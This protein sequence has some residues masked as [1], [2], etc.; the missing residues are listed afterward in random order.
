MIARK[1]IFLDSAQATTKDLSIG[2]ASFEYPQPVEAFPGSVKIALTSF[3]YTNFFIN[4]SAPNNVIYYSDD[5]LTPQKY[6]ITIPG[7]SYG[8]SDLNDFIQQQQMAQAGVAAVI[9]TI[10]PNYS[11]G[12]ISV[13]FGNVVGWFV[14]FEATS[15]SI[16]GFGV[17]H[18]P[19]TDANTA[20]YSEAAPNAASFNSVDQVK[21]STDLST[22]SIDN[23]ALSSNIIYTST[24]VV[25]IGSVQKDEPQHLLTLESYKLTQKCSSIMVQILDQNNIPINLSEDFSLS[26]IVL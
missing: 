12:K 16:L 2:R 9:W 23:S 5:A 24:P 15:P 18:V 6:T 3:R 1:V 10:Q 25:S 14:N 26:I 13:V 11:T 19:V 4:I 17:Q 8:W 22:D 20:Y 7:G 21:V